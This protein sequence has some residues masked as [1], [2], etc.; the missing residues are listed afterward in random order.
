ML[1][2]SFNHSPFCT[3]NDEATG[4]LQILKYMMELK[5]FA[6]ENILE[7]SLKNLELN[8]LLLVRTQGQTLFVNNFFS[9]HHKHYHLRVV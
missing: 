2:P 4:I 7:R 9:T 6:H 8:A 5:F 3:V 1:R